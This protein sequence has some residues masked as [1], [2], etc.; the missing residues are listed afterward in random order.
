MKA[1]YVGDATDESVPEN[2]SAFGVDFPKGKFVDVPA[3][4]EAKFVG[5]SHFE[6][7]GEAESEEGA[8]AVKDNK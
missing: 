7:K 4:K 1:K 5:N 6:V 2:F 8:E 3:D